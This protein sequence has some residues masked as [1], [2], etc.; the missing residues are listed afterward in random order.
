MTGLPEVLESGEEARLIPVVA[1]TSKEN[2]AASILLAE[3]VKRPFCQPVARTGSTTRVRHAPAFDVGNS[4][5]GCGLRGQA[6]NRIAG[7]A[8]DRRRDRVADY[9]RLERAD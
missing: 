7:P 3:S 4:P 2:R 6:A 5:A 1:D 9:E 8:A